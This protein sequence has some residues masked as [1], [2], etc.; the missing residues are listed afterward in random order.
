MSRKFYGINTWGNVLERTPGSAAMSTDMR[1]MPDFQLRVRSGRRA[2]MFNAAGT[3]IRKIHV[4]R[5]P[6]NAGA[7]T[8]Y[9]Q[10]MQA[11]IVRWESLA[12]STWAVDPF[13]NIAIDGH[14]GGTFTINAAAPS[15]NLRSRAVLYNGLGVRDA[16]N[17][18]P[19][20]CAGLNR[21]FGLD[22]YCPNGNPVASFAAGDGYN[23]IF[24]PVQIFVGLHN[25]GTGHFSNAVYAGTILPDDEAGT[26]T[27]S[28]LNK[29]TT[30][31]INAAERGELQYVFY[32]TIDGGSVPYLILNGTLDDAYKVPVTSTSANLSLYSG[33]FSGW[34]LDLTSEMPT[35]NHPPKPMRVICYANGRIYG[36]L[37]TGG[38]GNAVMQR[39]T[40]GRS[41]RDFT[42]VP[43]DNYRAGLV[44]SKS[45]ADMV[46]KPS[47]I[48]NPEESWPLT[49]FTPSPNCEVPIKVVPAPTIDER[50]ERVLAITATK[51][52]I[53][54]EAA[55]GFHEWTTIGATHG[56]AREECYVETGW[57]AIWLTQRNQVARYSMDYAQVA[58]ISDEYDSVV[59]GKSP[60]CAAY[61][62]DPV[63]EVDQV[64]FYF[65]DGTCLVHDF[66]LRTPQFVHGMGYLLTNQ[67]YTAG[68]S[69]TGTDGKVY[70]LVA[71]RHIYSVEGQP[72]DG[73]VVA[74]DEDFGSSGSVL[75]RANISGLWIGQDDDF[76]DDSIRKIVNQMDIDA[77]ESVQIGWYPDR[78]A[79]NDFNKRVIQPNAMTR[80][81]DTENQQVQCFRASVAKGNGRWF[82][83]QYGL[84]TNYGVLDK[85]PARNEL[86][87][88]DK[89]LYAMVARVKYYLGGGQDRP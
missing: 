5:A 27:V 8:H 74:Y 66:A 82:R 15:C 2:R 29:L 9:I 34:V 6:E 3:V 10:R 19:P 52:F 58:I 4:F 80:I 71:A 59:R 84:Q 85:Y 26:I 38:A 51:T 56:I 53:V 88:S 25:T 16:T 33:T 81:K 54:H 77:D 13:M 45:A 7:E 62:V 68:G 48:G 67:A 75:T 64:R 87:S 69:A 61:V 46:I 24:D 47:L 50:P 89:P 72:E 83:F 70:H 40:D 18:R 1:V 36:V 21:Y 60:V 37:M 73:K 17:S 12:I 20:F 43:S 78:L 63:N 11:S 44:Y 35:D 55:D 86:A 39:R 42:Y 22:A 65:A 32:A 14:Y 28:D 31:Y 57:G 30:A 41:Y 79:V 23:H 76:G 49:N